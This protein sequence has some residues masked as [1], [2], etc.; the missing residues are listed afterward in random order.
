MLSLFPVLLSYQQLSPFLIRLV[1]AGI[2]IYWS[3][4]G[5]RHNTGSKRILDAGQGIVGIFIL[6]GLWTQAAAGLAALGFLVCIV[7]KIR[8][9]KFL[10]DGVNYMLLLLIMAISLMLTGP[11]WWAYDMPL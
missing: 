7:G 2:M 8:D 10:T 1:L 4:S 5:I 3:Y 6:I 11:G 9:R